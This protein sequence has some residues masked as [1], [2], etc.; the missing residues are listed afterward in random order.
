[1]TLLTGMKGDGFYDRHSSYQRDT[2]DGVAS[3]IDQAVAAMNLPE[4]A[5]PIVVADYGCSEGRNSIHAVGRVVA[6]LRRR[7]PDQPICALHTDLP[8][9]NF[10]QLFLNLFDRDTENYLQ[11]QGQRKPNT[12]AGA[13]GGNFYGTMLAPRSVHFAL[14]FLAVQWMSRIPDVPVPHFISYKGAG[15]EV[16][17][18]YREQAT[19]DL[20]LFFQSRAEEMAPGGQLFLV[21][22]GS[23][24]EWSCAKVLEVLN[25]ACEDLV[26]AGRLDGERLRQFVFPLYFRTLEELIAPLIQ[27]G[28]PLA[29]AFTIERVETVVVPVSF[30]E[31]FRQT[32]STEVYAP[33]YTGFL[34][35]FSESVIRG[36]PTGGDP[37]LTDAIYERVQERLTVEPKRYLFENI[38]VALLLKRN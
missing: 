24:G 38:E 8:T 23:D 6:A 1:M 15:S 30:V 35:A 3:W 5:L 14:S 32:G 4:P 27:P 9:N 31:H 18:T 36:G 22:P 21:M 33:A 7:R 25:L 29:D 19:R 11:A 28:S 37:A 13:V 2:F 16:E 20:A 34:R 17:Q 26:A 12:Y 10:N